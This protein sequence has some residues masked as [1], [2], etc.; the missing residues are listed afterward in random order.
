[1]S[2]TDN[3]DRF[4]H[5]CVCHR[6]MM[7]KR[8]VDNKVIDM[9]LPEHDHTDFLLNNAS[10]MKVCMCKNCKLKV[11]LDS[12][13]VHGY[14]MEACLKGWELETK[15]LVEDKQWTQEQANNYLINMG[16]LNIHCH[17]EHLDK[18]NLQNKQ[19]ELLGANK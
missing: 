15:I 12:E 13:T 19:K 17:A 1:M 7:T 9:F 18:S 16:K 2:N 11:N 3:I 6:N 5:C 8:V 4:G 10:I 14:I